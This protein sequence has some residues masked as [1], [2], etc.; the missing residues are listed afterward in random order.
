MEGK[1]PLV[2]TTLQTDR[3]APQR[4]GVTQKVTI[5]ARSHPW[6]G[7]QLRVVHTSSPQGKEY[8]TLELPNGERRS[9]ARA[10][11]DFDNQEEGGHEEGRLLRVSVRT[12]LSVAKF[13]REQLRISEEQSHEHLSPDHSDRT[14]T[15]PN[16]EA[17]DVRG[18]G[19]NM[20]TAIERAT[21]TFGSDHQP[22]DAMLAGD[23]TRGGA[24]K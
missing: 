7:R 18:T 13:I 11:T 1:D 4:E 6:F 19:E 15:T 17:A 22:D 23:T 9:I 2:L 14:R 3:N 24:E 8:L 20:V 10:A 5:K 16:C 21:A 12:M